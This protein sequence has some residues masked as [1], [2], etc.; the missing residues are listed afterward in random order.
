MQQLQ[1]T[2]IYCPTCLKSCTQHTLEM[3]QP[4]KNSTKSRN[5]LL[6]VHRKQQSNCAIHSV[7]E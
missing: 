5:V 2:D 3:Y 6:T 7:T 1:H 4:T